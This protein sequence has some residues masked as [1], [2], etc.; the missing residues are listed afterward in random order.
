MTSFSIRRFSFDDTWRAGP[1]RE[2]KLSNW[3]VVY[4]LHDGAHRSNGQVY[5]GETLSLS[6]RMR[7][8]LDSSEKESLTGVEVILDETFNKSVCLDL[9]SHLIKL[10]AGD[11]S[12]AVL[13]RNDGV[14]DADY[15]ERPRYRQVFNS[16]FEELREL[17]LFERTIP[18]IIN[19]AL[20]KLS[21]FK[22]L[23]HDQAA[24]VEDILEGLSAD[25]QSHTHPRSVA[26]IQGEPGTGK[27]VVGI[28][29][30][31]LMVDLAHARDADSVDRDT[32]FSEFFLPGHREAFEGLRVGLVV[33][34]QSLRKSIKA[35]FAN[36]PGLT[37]SMVMTM[38]D[39]ADSEEEFD[40][41]IID[42]AHRLSQ[43]A[44]Q[45]HGSLTKRY[46]DVNARLFHG[47][48]PEASQ[49]EWAR[50]RAKHVI[51]LLD[52]GQSVRPGDISKAEFDAL[53]DELQASERKPYRLF[54]QMR[55]QGGND[56]IDYVRQILSHTPPPQR[57]DFG[58]YEV[59]LV[60]DPAQLQQLIT[61][62]ERQAGLAR[63]VAGYAWPWIS[64]RDNTKFDI[65]LGPG[66]RWQWNTTPVDWVNSPTSVN[67][68][69]SI[70]TIQ[71][72][73]LNYAGV[74]IGRDLRY[75]A[76]TKQLFIDR[77]SYFDVAG[78]RNN[79]MAGVETTDD[80]LFRYI[81]NIYTVLLTRGIKGTFIHAVDPGL[82]QYIGKFLP[83]L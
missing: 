54:T 32:M 22:S 71:G 19:S 13:N 50:N 31:K 25:L 70:H 68:A 18:E 53:L 69:G 9:E 10:A 66:A 73:D 74:I 3:P 8:H 56:Y 78:K 39:V 24:A 15:Y 28:Y 72:Y 5:I 48:R 29:L 57:L 36:T 38:F 42:E 26:V 77:N 60:E 43:Y 23:T 33:P 37:P 1:V 4:V 65:D 20:F 7:Q 27:T 16:I 58:D 76:D 80:M 30:M 83:T 52:S 55:S 82:Q 61:Q 21:P 34:Q 49:L 62:K 63:V 59:G 64:K 40:V 44:M 51:L 45:A 46:R 14:V 2:Q 35:V 67:E 12:R 47:Q 79:T 6:S 75:D 17:G 11:G 41:L 81:T